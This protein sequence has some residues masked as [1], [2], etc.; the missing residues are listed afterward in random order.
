MTQKTKKHGSPTFYTL[1]DKMSELHNMKSHDYASNED[2]YGNYHFAGALSKIFKN[3]DDA[4]FL[5][6]IGEKIYRL[7]NLENSGKVPK[8]ERVEDTE[9][10]LCVIMTLWIASRRDRRNKRGVS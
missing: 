4:G 9:D 7:A 8:N 10:D 3:P 5:G 6:R 2:P 1:L